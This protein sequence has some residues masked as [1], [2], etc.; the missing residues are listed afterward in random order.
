LVV[1]SK[2][3]LRIV[4]VPLP[5]VRKPSGHR[6]PKPELYSNGLANWVVYQNVVLGQNLL[7]IERSLREV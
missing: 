4:A 5:Q 6:D 2:V 7:K 1:V 3:V